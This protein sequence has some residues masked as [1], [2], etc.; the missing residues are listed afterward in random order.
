MLTGEKPERGVTVDFGALI[1]LQRGLRFGQIY[2][3]TLDGLRGKLQPTASPA[4]T[5]FATFIDCACVLQLAMNPNR[6]ARLTCPG[7]SMRC[8]TKRRRCRTSGES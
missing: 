6:V 8:R 5:R 3:A 2:A 4:R 7:R 1:A